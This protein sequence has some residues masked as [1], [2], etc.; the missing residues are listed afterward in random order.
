MD[1]VRIG[2]KKYVNWNGDAI[3]FGSF[4]SAFC[5]LFLSL[6][7]LRCVDLLP[8]V[9]SIADEHLEGMPMM[10]ML[11]GDEDTNKQIVEYF[12]WEVP[13]VQIDSHHMG[14]EFAVYE[15]PTMQIYDA[16]QVR[17]FS[18]VTDEA[19]DVIACIKKSKKE[20]KQP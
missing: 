19:E 3:Y 5:L 11:D 15:T 20:M 2:E 12:N 7:C 16:N 18:G 9:K 13:V 6:Y 8:H 1:K 10:V 4:D 17:I 14:D